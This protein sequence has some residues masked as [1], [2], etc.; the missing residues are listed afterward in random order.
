MIGRTVRAVRVVR[1]L[2]QS[3][4]AE[5]MGPPWTQQKISKIETGKLEL[6][7]EEYRQ[8]ARILR[9]RDLQKELQLQ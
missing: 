3:K 7:D 5:L 2:H 6:T 4:L 9:I 1:G 8:F